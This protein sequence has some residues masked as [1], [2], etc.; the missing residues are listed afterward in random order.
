M[1]CV[2]SKLRCGVGFA[3]NCR[4]PGNQHERQE[5]VR[6]SQDLETRPDRRSFLSLVTGLLA[7]LLGLLVAIPAVGYCLGPLWRKSGDD[8][9]FVDVGP[10]TNFPLG[11]WR[12]HALEVV[13]KDGWKQTR[14]RHAILV[15]RQGPG[16]REITVLSSICPHLGCPVTWHPEQS[17]FL[18]PC[19]GGVFDVDGKQLS[20][21]PP[22]GL[23]PL[24]SEV[25]AGH[26]WVRWQDFKIGVA[27]RIPVSA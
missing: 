15:R 10:I 9:T 27:D 21:P 6:N 26:L 1:A 5:A 4:H 14:A 20:G 11:E 18:C 17:E 19:H 16:D 2:C 24:E 25:R 13:Q 23:D 8:A 7:T 22:R 3:S 12:L